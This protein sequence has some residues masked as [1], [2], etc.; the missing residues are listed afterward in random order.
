[1]DRSTGQRRENQSLRKG[2]VSCE[3]EEFWRRI[4]HFAAVLGVS[5]ESQYF[6]PVAKV[7]TKINF[8]PLEKL[9]SELKVEGGE[10][11]FS[12]SSSKWQFYS[13]GLIDNL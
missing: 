3:S 10:V 6:Q 13:Q 9:S 7:Q 5:L 11:G 12:K 4:R 2:P 8:L 1:M